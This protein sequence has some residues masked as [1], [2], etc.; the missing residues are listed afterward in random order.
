MIRAYLG[1]FRGIGLMYTSVSKE[2]IFP[3]LELCEQ[4][5]I[6]ANAAASPQA[7]M[8]K[9]LRDLNSFM[10]KA[11]SGIK[12]IVTEVSILSAAASNGREPVVT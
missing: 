11:Q 2:Y 7:A 5:S 8:D 12:S 3:G 10:T 4:L 1:L 9:K 6:E